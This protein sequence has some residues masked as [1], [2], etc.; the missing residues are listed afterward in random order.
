MIEKRWLM[1]AITLFVYATPFLKAD[2]QTKKS[3]ASNSVQ[4]KA[5]ERLVEKVRKSIAGITF[6]GRDGK[7]QGLGTGFVIDPDG[8]I[9]TNLHLIG[10]ARPVRGQLG[11]KHHKANTRQPTSRL[12]HPPLL[13]R[14]P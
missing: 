7:R 10:E 4:S 5:V 11:G 13:P 3:D 12:L 1:I 14:H 2:D 8:L 9:A 6:T